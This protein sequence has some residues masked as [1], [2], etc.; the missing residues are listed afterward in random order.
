MDFIF[1]ANIA[2]YK[3]LLETETDAR[4]IAMLHKL[5]TEEEV[6]L[7]AWNAQNPRPVRQSK[8]ASVAASFNFESE[9]HALLT[10]SS[11]Q[12]GFH[13]HHRFERRSLRTS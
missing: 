6:K 10:R 13:R 1:H 3:K 2:H 11:F 12:P 4:K 7:A 8:A 9:G 5:M